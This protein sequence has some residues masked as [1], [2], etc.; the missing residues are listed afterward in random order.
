MSW[1]QLH[2]IIPAEQVNEFEDELLSLL[3]LSIT[4]QDA[5]DE[6]IFEPEVGTTPLWTKVKLTAL[7]D[8]SVDIKKIAGKLQDLHPGQILNVKTEMLADENWERTWLKHFKPMQFGDDFWIVPTGYDI[9]DNNAINLRLD[10]GLAFGTGT[11]PTTAMC[12]QWLA[13]NP[14]IG[15]TVIDYG[16]GSGILAIAALLLG[17]KE[18]WAIDYDPQALTATK[19]NAIRN[20]IN[21]ESLSLG[22]NAD[23]PSEH[24]ADIMIANILA[25]PLITLAPTLAKHVKPSGHIVLSGILADAEQTEL[26]AAAYH[27]FFNLHAPLELDG[28]VRL[29]GEK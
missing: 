18:V 9:P 3:A 1:Q 26:V 17:A 2:L 27:P 13:A 21:L 23:L 20:N 22:L 15:K 4:L 7:Y 16:C 14:P 19:D 28:W 6:P 24:Q 25:N 11:H 8:M 10:P 29:S 12:L 5:E